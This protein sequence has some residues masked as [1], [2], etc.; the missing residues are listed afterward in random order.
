MAGGRHAQI[1]T[2]RAILETFVSHGAK[3]R[4]EHR[5]KGE[6]TRRRTMTK[7]RNSEPGR[8]HRRIICLSKKQVTEQVKDQFSGKRFERKRRAGMF[9]PKHGLVRGSPAA[10]RTSCLLRHC[11]ACSENA[12]QVRPAAERR[13]KS[14]PLRQRY[15]RRALSIL[16][17]V[18]LLLLT[19]RMVQ[20]QGLETAV[21]TLNA[22]N[23][24]TDYVRRIHKEQSALLSVYTK[25][26]EEGQAKEHM[27][28]VED[29]L[30]ELASFFRA[31][32]FSLNL[33]GVS[34]IQEELARRLEEAAEH[35][36]REAL[37]ALRREESEW[38][39]V[40]SYAQ[41]TARDK[42]PNW[43][44]LTRSMTLGN[45]TLSRTVTDRLN[46]LIRELP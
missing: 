24:C 44:L 40:W 8:R 4:A 35:L 46:D 16:G 28:A 5:L 14:V 38:R 3:N 34:D 13:T 6:E 42:S 22:K 31:R 18:L 2:A 32:T 12:L 17:S 23:C 27:A 21:Q 33:P 26:I 11:A 29:C 9:W 39:H 30:S 19:V 15:V 43:S 41:S 10:H 37:S 7:M 20:A 25:S 1:R 45:T 36:C